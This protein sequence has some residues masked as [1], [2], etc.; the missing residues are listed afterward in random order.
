MSKG[1]RKPICRFISAGVTCSPEYR[2]L[3]AEGPSRLLF[4]F[5]L[6]HPHGGSFHVPGIY[7]VGPEALRETCGLPRRTFTRAFAEL[8]ERNIVLSDKEAHLLWMPAAIYLMGPP[9][10]PNMVKGYCRSILQLP[11]CE[12]LDIAIAA[13]RRFL[14]DLGPSFVQPFDEAFGGP[15]ERVAE[16]LGEPFVNGFETD[17]QT[18]NN[19]NNNKNKY[20]QNNS[21][22]DKLSTAQATLCGLSCDSLANGLDWPKLSASACQA[23]VDVLPHI[24]KSDVL[25]A[26]ATVMGKPEVRDPWA[27]LFAILM[28]SNSHGGKQQPVM[29][30]GEEDDPFADYDDGQVVTL[31]G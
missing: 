19:D 18:Y 3:G 30:A 8:H 29:H 12:L 11:S 22:R 15:T 9:A 20:N 16:I 17:C 27:Y 23:Y 13:Y 14:A 26:R 7:K 2:S 10:N 28:R 1:L 21:R 5:L 25:K 24:T 4:L 31:H 6:I